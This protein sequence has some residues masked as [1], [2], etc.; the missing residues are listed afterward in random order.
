MGQVEI[1]QYLCMYLIMSK[2]CGK[3]FCETRQQR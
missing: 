2:E 3:M 1:I